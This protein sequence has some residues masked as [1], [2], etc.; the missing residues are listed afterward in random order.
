MEDYNSDSN[1]LESNSN[2]T[3]IRSDLDSLTSKARSVKD[4]VGQHQDS[5][6]VPP[7]KPPVFVPRGLGGKPGP[8]A[9]DHKPEVPK[10]M[11]VKGTD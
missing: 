6:P 9:S 1:L 2:Q 7:R 3:S 11:M 4:I 5:S 8:K 10:K